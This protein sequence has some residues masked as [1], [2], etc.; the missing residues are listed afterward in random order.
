M[1]AQAGANRVLQAMSRKYTREYYLERVA[2]LRALVPDIEIAGDFI[3]GFPGE[4]DEEFEQTVDL[5]RR[6]EYLNCFI[7]KYSPRPGTAA[8]SLDDDVPWGV[9]KARNQRLL[10]E[11]E[12][13]MER[14]AADMVGG[15]VE[16]LVEGASKRDP[17]NVSGRTPGNRIVA[18]P[19]DESL[20]G[21]L[22]NVHVTDATA[23]TLLGHVTR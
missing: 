7:F 17:H 3:V 6:V 21:Q 23:L 2:R 20:A 22:V 13:V 16:V 4:T 19:G 15:T 8:A 9:K 10:A 18:F 5:V 11:E 1:P 14:R 12:A